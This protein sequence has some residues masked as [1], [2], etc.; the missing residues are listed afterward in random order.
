M[1]FLDLGKRI[2]LVDR[3][4]DKMA[5]AGVKAA[6]ARTQSKTCRFFGGGKCARS[7][8]E[9]GAPVPLWPRNRSPAIEEFGLTRLGDK[10]RLPS[11]P[12]PI[13]C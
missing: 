4:L 10:S 6:L 5:D 9:R 13:F 11:S 8:L 1:R 2:R 3:Y 12:R 7:V